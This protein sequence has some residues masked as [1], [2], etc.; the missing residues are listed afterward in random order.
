MREPNGAST[1]G[2]MRPCV[3][4]MTKSRKTV[5]ASSAA[6]AMTTPT[7]ASASTPCRNRSERKISACNADSKRAPFIGGR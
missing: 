7:P 2:S 5:A 3:M 1:Q 4:A 6:L